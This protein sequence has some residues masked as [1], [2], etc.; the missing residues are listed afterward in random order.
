MIVKIGHLISSIKY[1]KCNEGIAIKIKIIGGV[2]V[3]I[4][5]II[6]FS[7]ILILINLLFIINNIIYVIVDII[8]MI[9]KIV[10]SWKK[11]SCSINGEFLFWNLSF[12]QVIISKKRLI[13]INEF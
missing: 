9:I 8:I 12:I 2:A 4:N 7:E 1:N 6:W 13:F 3:Q 11:I 10:W 5:S